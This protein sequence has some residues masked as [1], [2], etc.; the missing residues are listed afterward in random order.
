MATRKATTKDR[1]RL[2]ADA[3][4]DQLV[5]VAAEIFRDRPFGDVSADEIAEAAGVAR[6]LINHHF[7]TKR[8]LYVEVVRRILDTSRVHV[9]EYRHGTTLRDRL[10][11][12]I[13]R[14]LTNIERHR[15]LWLASVRTAGIGDPDIAALA[16]RSREEAARKLSLVMGLGPVEELSPER[17]GMIRI[18]QSLAESA[19][20]QWLEYGRLTREQV[21]VLVIETGE[22]VAHGVMEEL[23]AVMGESAAVA[24]RTPEVP[25]CA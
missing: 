21:R 24:G 18:W 2:S 25:G 4:R 13:D 22:R 23:A 17:L 19:A 3:R 16:E 9:P 6:G 15:G 7:G 12:S 20:C 10:D 1:E 5:T 14:W 11:E 8:G